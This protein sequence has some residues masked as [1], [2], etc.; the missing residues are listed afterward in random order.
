MVRVGIIGAAGL[1]GLELLHLLS[2]HSEAAVKLVTSTKYQGKNVSEVFPELYQYSLTFNP[3][4]TD[5]LGCDVVFLAIPNQASLEIVPKLLDKGLR[6]IDLSG[7]YR[8]ADT[9]VFEKFYKLKHT[10]PELLKEAV[11]GLPEFFSQ[12]ISRARLVSNP[13]CYSTCALLGILPLAE[14]LDELDQPPVIDAKSGVTGAGGRVEDDSMNYVSVNENFKAYKVFSHQHQPEIQQYLNELS[15]YSSNIKGEVIFTPHLLPVNR[16]IL[17]TIYIHFREAVNGDQ[18]IRK[19]TEFAD[20]QKFVEFMGKGTFPDIKMTS[21]TNRC[22]I[23]A[24]CDQS[25]RNWVIVSSLD[26]LIKGA[27]GQAIQ[28]MN[29]MFGLDE[30]LGLE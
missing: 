21:H 20:K 29:I 1:S 27:A 4:E 16:G 3:N 23:G 2:R 5:V 10:Y 11:F 25:G 17:S 15:S 9:E 12:Q 26:N 19:F 18:V 13:G 30:S 24:E 14:M 8:L 6:V 7:A 22:M 28:N